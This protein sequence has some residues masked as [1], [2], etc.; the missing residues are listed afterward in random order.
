MR[1]KLKL[2]L[3][4]LLVIFADLGICFAQSSKVKNHFGNWPKGCSP[5][6]I[7]KRVA[8][9]FLNPPQQ[10]PGKK[11]PLKKIT[12]PE[13]CTWYGALTFAKESK[14]KGLAQNL[15]KRFEPFWGVKDSLIPHPVHV[16]YTVFGIVPLEI[17]IQNKDK[18]CLELGLNFA[19]KQWAKPENQHLTKNAEDFVQHG[20]TWQTR[21]WI[22]DMFMITSIQCQA[23]RATGDKKYI[24]R[25][26]KEMAMYLDSLQRPNGLFYHA[27]QTPFYWGRGNGWV[28]VG[29]SDLLRL[30]PKDNIYRK[31]I[32][33]G[34]QA[35]MATLLKY[36]SKEGMWRQLVDDPQSWPETSGTGMFTYAM[37][38]GVKYGW[39]DKNKYSPAVRKAWLALVGYI[40]DKNEIREVCEGTNQKN[41]RQYYLDRKRN[42][43]DLHGQAPVLWCATAFLRK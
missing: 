37:I 20:Y 14:D 31:R 25:A 1:N 39:L 33:K 24:N 17:Y 26:A 22:D 36:Q 42:T 6:E 16:D 29:M 2:L 18:R 41:N 11:T 12:Y 30:L 21:L 28:A 15:A 7:G 23:Y 5:E 38:N 43:G 32:M 3:I 13:V 10:N 40:N 8:E 35:M 9:R 19:D 4:A 34:Y 27:P